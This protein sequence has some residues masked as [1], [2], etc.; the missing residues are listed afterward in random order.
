[1]VAGGVIALGACI[2][3]VLTV[4]KDPIVGTLSIRPSELKGIILNRWLLIVSA[5]LI[6]AQVA[7]GINSYFMVYYLEESLRSSAAV[8][9][10]IG[11]FT[12]VISVLISPFVGRAFDKSPSPKKTFILL[13]R[14]VG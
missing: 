8:A 1:M 14:R 7:F 11:G 6:V 12:L 4:P 10:A 13:P 9:G 2:L 5:G 3:L